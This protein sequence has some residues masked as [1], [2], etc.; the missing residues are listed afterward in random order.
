MHSEE[1]EDRVAEV[2]VSLVEEE[3]R[4]QTRVVLGVARWISGEE[5]KIVCVAGAE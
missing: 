1:E 5:R 4:L 2:A 3:W